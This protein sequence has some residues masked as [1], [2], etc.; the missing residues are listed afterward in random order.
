[1]LSASFGP[2]VVGPIS[3]CNRHLAVSFQLFLSKRY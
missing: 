1:M 3:T 2:I